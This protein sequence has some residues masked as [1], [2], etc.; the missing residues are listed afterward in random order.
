M[1]YRAL[2]RRCAGN[3]NCTYAAVPGRIHG[4]RRTLDSRSRDHAE[5]VRGVPL[6][7]DGMM[8]VADGSGAAVAMDRDSSQ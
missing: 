2:A 7:I 4:V 5:S 6:A 8:C 1:R 3:G